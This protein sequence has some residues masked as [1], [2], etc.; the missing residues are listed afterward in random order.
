MPL[1]GH[2]GYLSY[3][4]TLVYIIFKNVKIITTTLK[5]DTKVIK[6]RTVTKKRR[7]VTQ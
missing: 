6:P 1:L 2:F 3:Y 4:I 7:N 5:N